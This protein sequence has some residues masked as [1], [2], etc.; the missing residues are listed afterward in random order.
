MLDMLHFY[1][2]F[3]LLLYLLGLYTLASSKNMIK[4]VMGI[5]ILVSAVNLNFLAFAAFTTGPSMIGPQVD[6]LIQ[7][8]VIISICIGGA[9][10]V[11]AMSLIIKAYK[12]Y[13]TLD[14]REL[15]RLK[16]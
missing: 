8:F 6:P 7:D 3:A 1:L 10:A 5:E 2:I 14:I 12:H 15:R 9:I 13:G 4:L 11:V 16:G